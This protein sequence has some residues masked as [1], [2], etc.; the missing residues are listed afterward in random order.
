MVSFHGIFIMDHQ[1]FLRNS[2]RVPPDDGGVHQLSDGRGLGARRVLQLRRHQAGLGG[3][4]LL[5]LRGRRREGPGRHQVDMGSSRVGGCEYSQY[6]SRN[7]PLLMSEKALSRP[8]SQP[9]SAP[10]SIRTDLL[11]LLTLTWAG[12][13]TLLAAGH[14]CV[15]ISFSLDSRCGTARCHLQLHPPPVVD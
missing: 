15:P 11:P 1:S 2:I 7:S 13:T 12:P 6:P 3:A 4:R 14:N 9:S 5:H 8:V 10:P